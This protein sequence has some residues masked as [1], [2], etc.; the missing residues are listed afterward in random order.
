VAEQRRSEGRVV[1]GVGVA[2]AVGERRAARRSDHELLEPGNAALAAVD[3]ARDHGGGAR[4]EIGL[5]CGRHRNLLVH[6]VALDDLVVER[7]ADAGGCGHEDRPVRLERQQLLRQRLVDRRFC[8][9]IFL[10]ERIG[11]DGIALK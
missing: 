8:N 2:L 1:V 3:T 5:G 9:T 7:D 10:E 11:N 4:S 6:A